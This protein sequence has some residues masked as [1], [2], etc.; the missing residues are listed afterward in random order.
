M[1]KYLSICAVYCMFDSYIYKV[2]ITNMQMKKT[3]LL[4][5]M[6]LMMGLNSCDPDEDVV[7]GPESAKYE[8]SFSFKDAEGRNLVRD[9]PLTE[10]YPKDLPVEQAYQGYLADDSYTVYISPMDVTPPQLYKNKLYMTTADN[11]EWLLQNESFFSDYK[12]KNQA[13]T[14]QIRFAALFGDNE[15][16][17]LKTYWTIPSEK[18]YNDHYAICNRAVLDG[19][20]LS[21]IAYIDHPNGVKEEKSNKITIV[22]P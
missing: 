12:E 22:I 15:E 7:Y 9:L 11:G 10:W 16:H 5:L 14:F 20:E 8:V 19:Q 21:D 1:N 18:Y 6:T 3:V 17:E 2:S 4:S 13:Y